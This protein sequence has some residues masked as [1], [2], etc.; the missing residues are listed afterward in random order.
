MLIEDDL[1]GNRG[2]PI[3]VVTEI[4][5]SLLVRG[6]SVD[7]NANGKPSDYHIW[8]DSKESVD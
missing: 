2:E 4:L 6:L 3:P 8:N 7:R 1:Q 5:D